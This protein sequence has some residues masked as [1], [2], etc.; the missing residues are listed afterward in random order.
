MKKIKLPNPTIM[1][2]GSM[3]A[4][5][6]AEIVNPGF[7]PVGIMILLL[8]PVLVIDFLYPQP[9]LEQLI[10]Q[11]HPAIDETMTPNGSNTENLSNKNLTNEGE[12]TTEAAQQPQ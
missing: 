11:I 6:L 10:E 9:E 7:N 8:I 4:F 1:I 12:P 5:W 3:G 2:F